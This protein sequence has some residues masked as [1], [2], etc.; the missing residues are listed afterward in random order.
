MLG[1][2]KVAKEMTSRSLKMCWHWLRGL[3]GSGDAERMKKRSECLK[4]EGYAS[5]QYRHNGLTE[6]ETWMSKEV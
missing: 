6:K 5:C 2:S 1:S 3:R 4:S